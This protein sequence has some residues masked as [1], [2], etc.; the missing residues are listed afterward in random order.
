MDASARFEQ[1]KTALHLL[2]SG[3]S[4]GEVAQALSRSPSWVYKWKARYQDHNDFNDLKDRSRAPKHRPTR[5]SEQVCKAI[6][7]ARSQLEAEAAS[8]TGLRYIGGPAVQARLKDQGQPSVPSLRS[9]ERELNRAEMTRPSKA[10]S[11][12]VPY[13]R[14]QPKTPH[15][16]CQV[17][18]VPHQLKAGPKVACFNAIDTV[19]GYATGQSLLHKRATDACAFLVHLWREQG[20]ARYTQTDNEGCFSGGFTHQHVLGQVLRLCL[21]V[22]TELVFSPHYHPKSNGHVERFHQD[23]DEHVWR[24]GSLDDLDAINEASQRFFAAYRHSGHLRKLAGQ[25]PAHVHGQQAAQR[26]PTGFLRPA[27]RLPLTEGRVHFMRQV[28]PAETVSIL[29]VDW[30]VEGVEAGGG[31]WATLALRC[32]DQAW[33]RLYD[34]AP[35]GGQRR[36]LIKHAFPLKEAVHPLRPEFQRAES[37]PWGPWARRLY[38]AFIRR[39]AVWLFSTM[40]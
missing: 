27:G 3:L 4:L 31:V 40:S 6:R 20:L 35:D 13:P 8:G 30:G 38:R 1:R 22:G 7:G 12:E 16:L 24:R 18:I 2:R 32:P 5:L 10:K 36:C 28:S 9:I 39:A 19:S 11:D 23:Y 29:N 33:L 14:L 25:S 17:D 37:D 26:L 21:Y 34:A 15:T